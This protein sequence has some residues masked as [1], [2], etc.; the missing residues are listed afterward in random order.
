MFSFALLI[1]LLTSIVTKTIG[2]SAKQ[3]LSPN[4]TA[5]TSF[6]NG[7]VFVASNQFY[8]LLN[9]NTLDLINEKSRGL[10]K[11]LIPGMNSVQM[12][13]SLRRSLDGS[14]M[15][16]LLFQTVCPIIDAIIV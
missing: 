7:T 11:N 13:V 8:W 4:I 1:L 2:L 15:E 10:I 12:A 9:N 3:C 5:I 6:R 16:T 14:Q